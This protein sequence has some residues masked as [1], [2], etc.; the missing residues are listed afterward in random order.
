MHEFELV[1]LPFL[2]WNLLLDCSYVLWVLTAVVCGE[3]RPTTVTPMT[4]TGSDCWIPTI[5]G[6]AYQPS[7]CTFPFEYRGT[8]YTGCTT[9]DNNG[10]AWC[11][12]SYDYRNDHL[13]GNCEGMFVMPVVLSTVSDG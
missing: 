13:W 7:V 12:T 3:P 11:Y 5:G 6:S 9:R 1:I 10:Y 8:V 2:S 4:T